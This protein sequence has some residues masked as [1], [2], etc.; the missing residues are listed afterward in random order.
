MSESKKPDLG[1]SEPLE[2]K[3]A[4][5]KTKP[6]NAQSIAKADSAS[7]KKSKQSETDPPTK[8]KSSKKPKR[9]H[10]PQVSIDDLSIN[11]SVVH[12]YKPKNKKKTPQTPTSLSKSK[13]KKAQQNDKTTRSKSFKNTSATKSKSP[14]ASLKTPKSKSK[15]KQKKRHGRERSRSDVGI[16]ALQATKSAQSSRKSKTKPKPGVMKRRESKDDIHLSTKK[17]KRASTIAGKHKQAK[18]TQ[19]PKYRTNSLRANSNTLSTIKQ[20]DA[21]KRSASLRATTPKAKRERAKSS[22]KAIEKGSIKSIRSKTPQPK[23]Q[24]KKKKQNKA[25]PLHVDI[26]H[27]ATDSSSING[28]TLYTP[29]TATDDDTPA[30]FVVP[31]LTPLAEDKEDHPQ[32]K[33]AK[34]SA[35]K[36][37]KKKKGN[38]DK[39]KKAVRIKSDKKDKKQMTPVKEIDA[40]YRNIMTPKT[41]KKA[42]WNAGKS[43]SNRK[44]K[45]SLTLERTGSNKKRESVLLAADAADAAAQHLEYVKMRQMYR[46]IKKDLKKLKGDTKALETERRAMKRNQ[47]K[48]ERDKEQFEIDARTFKMKKSNVGGKKY[49]VLEED[50]LRKMLYAER[51]QWNEERKNLRAEIMRL[52]GQL[53]SKRLGDKH[54]MSAFKRDILAGMNV[55][56]SA[57]PHGQKAPSY[58]RQQKELQ[59]FIRIEKQR[60]MK[61]LNAEKKK[62]AMMARQMR[63]EHARRKKQRGLGPLYNKGKASRYNRLRQPEVIHR[64]SR[65]VKKVYINRGN[66]RVYRR[67]GNAVNYRPKEVRIVY[68]DLRKKVV[69]KSHNIDTRIKYLKGQKKRLNII[70]KKIVPLE[71]RI[72]R[73]KYRKRQQNKKKK[74][75]GGSKGKKK[76]KKKKKK[77]GNAT[78]EEMKQRVGINGTGGAGDDDDDEEDDEWSDSDWDSELD[79]P[80]DMSDEKEKSDTVVV[81]DEADKVM[82]A[83]PDL[84][85]ALQE[86][87]A[88]SS[89]YTTCQQEMDKAMDEMMDAED[90][91]F[92]DGNTSMD[93][94]RMDNADDTLVMGSQSMQL[95]ESKEEDQFEMQLLDLENEL[96]APT[97]EDF[98]K[99]VSKMEHIVSEQAEE[100][101]TLREVVDS[102][103]ERLA[104]AQLEIDNLKEIVRGAKRKQQLRE[105][106]MKMAYS[107]S[108]PFA[109]F[110]S[111]HNPKHLGPSTQ[112]QQVLSV[113]SSVG[114][115]LA[116]VVD[117]ED[118]VIIDND[119]NALMDTDKAIKM[120]ADPS[121]YSESDLIKAANSVYVRGLMGEEADVMT[122]KNIV[123]ALL[124]IIRSKGDQLAAHPEHI[125]IVQAAIKALVPLLTDGKAKQQF[126]GK[127]G[128]DVLDALFGP[129][130]MNSDLKHMYPLSSFIA[131]CCATTAT[132]AS[133][134]DKAKIDD[135]A[136]KLCRMAKDNMN[137]SDLMHSFGGLLCAMDTKHQANV[138]KPLVEQG[139]MDVTTSCSLANINDHNGTKTAFGLCY[140]HVGDVDSFLFDNRHVSLDDLVDAI[141]T[142]GMDNSSDVLAHVLDGICAMITA[143]KAKGKDI[144]RQLADKGLEPVLMRAVDKI[145]NTEEKS[146]EESEDHGFAMQS[147]SDFYNTL[148]FEN[149]DPKMAQ[150]KSKLETL[151]VPLYGAKDWARS[152]LHTSEDTDTGSKYDFIKNNESDAIQKVKDRRHERVFHPKV[153]DIGGFLNRINQARAED[154]DEQQIGNMRRRAQEQQKQMELKAEQANQSRMSKIFT[155]MFK[156]K[157]KGGKGK[158]LM[159]MSQVQSYSAE[160]KDSGVVTPQQGLSPS[161]SGILTRRAVPN[162][163]QQQQRMFSKQAFHKNGRKRIPRYEDFMNQAFNDKI[164]RGLNEVQ[165]VFNEMTHHTGMV[166]PVGS[167]LQKW[168]VLANHQATYWISQNNKELERYDAQDAPDDYEDMDDEEK[169]NDCWL[170]FDMKHRRLIQEIRWRNRGQMNDPKYITIQSSNSEE[171][172]WADISNAFLEKT[173]DE[174]VIEVNKRARYWRIMFLGNHGEDTDDA[175]RF[176]FYEVQFWGRKHSTMNYSKAAKQRKNRDRYGSN[177]GL[178]MGREDSMMSMSQSVTFSRQPEP[179]VSRLSAYKM[180]SAYG[181]NAQKGRRY[182]GNRGRSYSGIEMTGKSK[183]STTPI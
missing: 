37:S 21:S 180:T 123:S 33:V 148:C 73:V 28:E 104:A 122:D 151:N 41:P 165:Q 88:L 66:S 100:A 109:Q 117:E 83:D 68:R 51:K 12:K 170:L 154:Y 49:G 147:I 132:A 175:P 93:Q 129:D 140:D 107:T 178:R 63:A 84:A 44:T 161:N 169:Y 167:M 171:T 74:K 155:G 92:E 9:K 138:M 157:D 62:L 43:H 10:Q 143:D 156:K 97:E 14:K 142:Y 103:S 162:R 105:L 106:Y 38:K 60:A 48:L 71:Q 30:S 134:A 98:D 87:D 176:V 32:Q 153:A 78:E 26:P 89:E 183:F 115:D 160:S 35:K 126:F 64:T 114:S 96:N 179:S 8:K 136:V 22:A 144:M 46:D 82:Q 116:A 55:G 102:L 121:N 58:G 164:G 145:Q 59:R 3:P 25:P 31:S 57:H 70:K 2:T 119:G 61:D 130:W 53:G 50:K 131:D 80:L 125:P 65:V 127:K 137:D 36:R 39:F 75:D 18:S 77:K 13:K 94:E 15:P 108:E 159:S 69:L 81:D 128:I 76:K 139:I 141:D 54:R 173:E 52:Q 79:G 124:D 11:L 23:K 24:K 146:D 56:V 135:I 182:Q 110:K 27:T 5:V 152:I 120:I 34:V 91:E 111:A 168:F 113:A 29:V 47:K 17:R 158:G 40:K 118:L 150:L 172:P 67:N 72:D 95:D 149:M 174:Q 85:K 1:P 163:L 6:D 133:E 101:G 42:A 90:A 99:E 4:D 112:H 86:L 16:I 181:N 7:T 45:N 177:A 20:R 166:R 19:S